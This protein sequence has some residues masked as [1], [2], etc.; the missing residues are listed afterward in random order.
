[1]P[2]GA[3]ISKVEA[4]RELGAEV[5]L[6]PGVYDDAYAKAMQLNEEK[7]MTFIHPF[8]DEQV[9]AGQGTVGM[10]ILNENPD[11]DVIFVPIGGGGLA[12]GVAFAVKALKPLCVWLVCRH[13][14][15]R[16]C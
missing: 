8:D 7:H 12:S 11:I 10:E 3:P 13:K 6:V 2:S 9:I 16:A 14:G 15:L 5:C 4:T 1:M